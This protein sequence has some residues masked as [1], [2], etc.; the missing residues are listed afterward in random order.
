VEDEEG[1]KTTM[2]IFIPMMVDRLL[3]TTNKGISCLLPLLP[4]SLPHLKT[5]GSP[6]L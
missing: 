3:V 2:N 5:K 1:E 6:G 4:P